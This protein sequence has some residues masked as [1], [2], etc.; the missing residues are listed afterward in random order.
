MPRSVQRQNRAERHYPTMPLD[1]IKV[2]PVA[3]L[4]A[5]DCCL[6]LWTIDSFLPAALQVGIAWGF[7]FKTVA[8]YWVK[9]ARSHSTARPFPMGTGYWTR[10]NPEQCLLF[11]RGRPKRLSG[12]V[13][14]LIV[15]QRREHSRKPD[16]QYDRI[17][18][19]VAGPYCELFARHRRP[20]W[21]AWGN[22]LPEQKE[23]E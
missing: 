3:S 4:A 21:D 11:T 14:K 7:V 1:E 16:E 13:E 18:A 15:A 10:A 6:F 5:T 12:G 22:Q 23:F 20:G 8:F 9:T 17:E 2:V 19:L